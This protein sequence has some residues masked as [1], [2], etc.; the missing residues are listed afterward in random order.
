[1]EENNEIIIADEDNILT[2]VPSKTD[3]RWLTEV[4]QDTV[5]EFNDFLYHYAWKRTLADMQFEEN[6]LAHKQKRA[7]V[8]L[9]EL[10]KDD[11]PEAYVA[12]ANIASR[13]AHLRMTVTSHLVEEDVVER[14]FLGQIVEAQHTGWPYL[15]PGSPYSSIRDM[16]MDMMPPGSR[17]RSLRSDIMFLATKLLG[18]M[19]YFQIDPAIIVNIS[20]NFSKARASVPALR[21]LWDRMDEHNRNQMQIYKG[22]D[23]MFAWVAGSFHRGGFKSEDD[24][25]QD[26]SSNVYL[27][28]SE[29]EKLELQDNIAKVLSDIADPDVPFSTFVDRMEGIK[30]GE[31]VEANGN[32]YPI[33][34]GE[35][36]IVVNCKSFVTPLIE[37]RLSGIVSDMPIRSMDQMLRWLKEKTR[38]LASG[39][40]NYVYDPGLRELIAAEANVL[41]IELPT[42]DVIQQMALEQIAGNAQSIVQ[43][44]N[45][46]LDQ[47]KIM[48]HPIAKT[49][50]NLVDNIK[51]AMFLPS[52]SVEEDMKLVLSDIPDAM[53]YMYKD[54]IR[55][56]SK[57]ALPELY[58][59]EPI[60]EPLFFLG[61]WGL[62]V[63]ITKKG[64]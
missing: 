20:E 22:E 37:R 40:K 29:K 58:R 60:V 31:P 24:A 54:A 42:P 41:G 44:L 1:M 51:A 8:L 35:E 47:W 61:Q 56:A 13:A 32:I 10:V 33:G 45:A 2:S 7:S 23:G 25:I 17:R 57:Q 59:A 3:T 55:Q 36:L 9:A 46:G 53:I 43:A 62:A 11:S 30:H 14:A 48:L 18:A 39:T 38:V 34:G 27:V 19:Q 6:A 15:L 4:T 63:K 5:R 50:P 64:G 21:F 49:E 12:K 28:A 26:F 16:L 52:V